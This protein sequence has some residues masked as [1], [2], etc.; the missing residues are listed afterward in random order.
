MLMMKLKRLLIKRT[1]KA[2]SFGVLFVLAFFGCIGLSG[3]NT[4]E[5]LSIHKGT[6]M[7]LIGN[8]LGARMMHYG[9]FETEVQ[10]K[11]PDSLLVI[12]NLCD[13]G[14]TPGFRPHSGRNEPWA[15]PG[16]AQ[17]QDDLAQ[18]SGSEGHFETPDQWLERLDTDLIIGF[19]GFNES[20]KDSAG[21]A[22]FMNELRAFITHTQGQKYN[23]IHAPEL[24]LVSPIAFQD[25][26]KT[27]DLPDGIEINRRLKMY[28]HAM[29]QVALE[30]KIPF[31][32]VFTPSAKWFSDKKLTIDGMQLNE[33]GYRI[34][35]SFLSNALFYD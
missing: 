15:F 28:T 2:T 17:F 3:C 9:F 4:S 12:R 26:S 34:F 33:E 25:L 11:F 14:N 24:V 31:I 6:R 23:G 8:N 21:L 7:A 20:F 10:L 18:K 30:E 27:E 13:G 35:S 22:L 19:F 32:D 5:K 29:A 1:K 16:A